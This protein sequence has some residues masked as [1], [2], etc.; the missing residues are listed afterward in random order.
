VI[1]IKPDMK[2]VS[3]SMSTK[4]LGELDSL[5]KSLGFAGRS[6]AVRAGIKSLISENKSVDEAKGELHAILLVVH[7][8]HDEYSLMDTKHKYENIIVTQ[9]HNNLGND[10][11]LEVFVLKG[12]ADKIRKLFKEFKSNDKMEYVKLVVT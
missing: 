5:Q 11:C 9:I 12:D 2:I 6:E 10:S 3:L 8:E 4:M 1:V 7:D